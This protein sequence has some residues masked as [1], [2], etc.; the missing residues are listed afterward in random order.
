MAS[1]ALLS[2][3]FRHSNGT[4]NAHAVGVLSGA[5]GYVLT[6]PI[7][8][9]ALT[10]RLGRGAAPLSPSVPLARTQF[11]LRKCASAIR[12]KQF[13]NI[14]RQSGT[15]MTSA[16]TG[17]TQNDTRAKS[18]S[19]AG[20]TRFDPLIEYRLMSEIGSENANGGATAATDA[21]CIGTRAE[22]ATLSSV[23]SLPRKPGR[24]KG[25][26]KVPGSGRQKGV[27]NHAGDESRELIFRHGQPIKFLS[28]IVRGLRVRVGAQAG[29]GAPEWIY[30]SLND[31]LKAAAI[32]APKILPDLTA[33]AVKAEVE[34]IG[35]MTNFEL[36][37]GI[38]FML[39]QGGRETEAQTEKEADHAS[40]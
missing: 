20:L 24:P 2:P 28:D 26:G 3:F 11:K 1:L 4:A 40:G 12:G 29:P 34:A 21:P 33:I 17:R 13:C 27:P 14:H 30:P 37:R 36:A 18:L 6:P 39:V 31:R 23:L 9:Y 8:P 22:A 5:L 32:L 15:A 38:A 25:L 35:E 10:R 16:D 7:P 19:F